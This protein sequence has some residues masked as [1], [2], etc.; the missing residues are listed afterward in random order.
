MNS[1]AALSLTATFVFILRSYC[2]VCK[3]CKNN[4]A[5]HYK[6]QTTNPIEQF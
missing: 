3:T 2:N 4:G 5:Q 6:A 1:L